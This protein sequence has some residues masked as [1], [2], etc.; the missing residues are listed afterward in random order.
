MV[1]HMGLVYV[2][3]W[4]S[5]GETLFVGSSPTIHVICSFRLVVRTADFHSANVGSIPARNVPTHTV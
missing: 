2:E 1:E 4:T 3:N 5:H